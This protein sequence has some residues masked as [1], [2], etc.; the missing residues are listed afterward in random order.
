MKAT[1]VAEIASEILRIGWRVDE[2]DSRLEELVKADPRGA[3]VR[4]LPGMGLVLTAEFLAEVGDLTRFG[5]A[6]RLAASAG[7]VPVLRASGKVSYQRRARKGNRALKRV[8]YRSAFC[9][10]S[11]HEPSQEYYRRKRAEGK[12]AQQAI[13]ALARRRVNVLWA[14]LRDGALYEDH[15]AEAA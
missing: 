7:V 8:F 13:I 14:M 9:A 4:S 5:S 1:L 15:A 6:D 3:V 10:L 11:C 2:L 12:G